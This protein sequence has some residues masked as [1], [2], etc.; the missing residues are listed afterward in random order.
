VN[1]EGKCENNDFFHFFFLFRFF[2]KCL[3][4]KENETGRIDDLAFFPFLRG[5]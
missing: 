2:C 3:G 4:V 5:N 1:A